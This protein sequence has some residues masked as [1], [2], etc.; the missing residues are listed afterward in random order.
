MLK[1]LRPPLPIAHNSDPLVEERN[2]HRV[3]APVEGDLVPV[4]AVAELTPRLAAVVAASPFPYDDCF[5]SAAGSI[6]E[7]RVLLQDQG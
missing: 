5:A 2:H 6:Q 1:V 7:T 3:A 4:A